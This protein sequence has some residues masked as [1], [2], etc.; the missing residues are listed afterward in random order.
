MKFII[1]S[2]SL[3]G[4]GLLSSCQ[5]TATPANNNP[6]GVPG[7]QPQANP[8][9]APLANGE[10]GTYNPNVAPPQPI[11]GVNQD[12][13]QPA[14]ITQGA[15][16]YGQQAYS[17]PAPGGSTTSHTVVSGDSLWGLAKRYN[18]TI[19]EIQVANSLTSTLIRTGQTLQIPS[20]Q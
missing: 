4:L 13:Y 12:A 18:T 8:Y 11:P 3:I 1:P 14:P 17:Q 10:T 16:N 20:G 2:L 6:Y 9:A 5:Q 15:Q 19:E 7:V